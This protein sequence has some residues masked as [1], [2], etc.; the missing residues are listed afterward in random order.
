MTTLTE[1]NLEEALLA[2]LH[3]L[4]APW[5]DGATHTLGSGSRVFPR[6]VFAY[7]EAPHPQPLWVWGEAEP[8]V[9]IR[10]LPVPL[11]TR[12]WGEGEQIRFAAAYRFSF[13]VTASH[14]EKGQSAAAAQAAAVCLTALLN[15]PGLAPELAAAGVGH[16]RAERPAAVASQL[17]SAVRVVN[18]QADCQWFAPV[19]AP[20]AEP[21]PEDAPAAPVLTGLSF[22]WAGA[23]ADVTLTY[24]FAPGEWPVARL[25]V[26]CAV[27]GGA[28]FYAGNISPS[29][30]AG[31]FLHA[32]AVEGEALLSYRLR[33]ANDAGVLGPWSAVASVEV[34][35]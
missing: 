31:T 6:A 24:T 15:H 21:G 2:N 5:F 23:A 32:Q 8:Q 9:E 35:L 11:F 22:A 26:W 3:E 20:A 10:C 17:T 27:D 4:L 30:S 14:P 18:A 34:T 16:L 33:Y 25:Q 12:K 19:P 1:L 28:W 7:N 13:W 29:A